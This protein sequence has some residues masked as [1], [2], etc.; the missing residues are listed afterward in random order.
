MESGVAVVSLF[1]VFFELFLAW[2]CFL[3]VVPVADLV[4]PVLPLAGVGLW[5]AAWAKLRALPSTSVQ[6]MVNSF[7]MRS[8]LK[9]INIYFV[10]FTNPPDKK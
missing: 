1:L 4:V 2:V 9:E 10:T 8:P 3:L 7:F 5:D 6:A